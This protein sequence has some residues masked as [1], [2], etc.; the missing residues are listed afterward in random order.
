[1][2][3]ETKTV[4]RLW[5]EFRRHRNSADAVTFDWFVLSLDLL[6]MLGAIEFERGRIRRATPETASAGAA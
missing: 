1:M 2:L 3:T 4:S 6:F 5:D